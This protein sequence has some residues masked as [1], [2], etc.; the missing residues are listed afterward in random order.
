MN[1]GDKMITLED[2]K[3]AYDNIVDS[4]KRT[5]ITESI[6]LNEELNSNIYF[7]LENLQR[8]GS[9]KM[10]GAVNKIASLTDEERKRGI[11]ASSAGNHA[12]GVALAAK[13]AGIKSTIVM[14]ET[15]PLSKVA[16]TKSY[17]ANVIQYGEMFDDA[18]SKA[19][20]VQKEQ[21]SVFVHAFNDDKIIAGQGTVGLEIIEDIPNIDTVIVPIG[22][23]GI[24]CGIAVALKTINPKIR[25]IG[26]EAK[27]VPS[28]T[29]ALKEDRIHMVHTTT[30]TI[31][32][33]IAVKQVGEK[34][35]EIA[36]Q[37]I[38]DIVLV[39]EDEISNAILYLLEKVKVV[40]EGAG[41]TP[42][43]AILSGKI[44]DIEG[45]NVCLVISGGNVD[46][47]D[48]EKIV[49]KSQILDGR[50]CEIVIKVQ[51]KSG[52][53]NKITTVLSENNANILYINQTR[54]SSE[55][56]INE[57]ELN[58]VFESKNRLHRDEILNKLSEA[59]I[60]FKNL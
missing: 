37:Y 35:F 49:N 39:T 2:I 57:Q 41:A 22:G 10:R 53:T 9:F 54:Y 44:K 24:I 29:N 28:M 26:V 55:L 12:Q 14:P 4:I 33:G 32:D 19:L 58:I 52:E 11:I 27:A 38:D 3:E 6:Q 31:A 46:V 30:K 7:K 15:A 16:A 47:N 50:R 25:I 13:E 18:Y 20:E 51:D 8:T 5:P 40:T 59:N 23:G 17:G 56:G 60:K 1:N 34:T 36:K 42:L 48:I 21:N 43:A 45:K